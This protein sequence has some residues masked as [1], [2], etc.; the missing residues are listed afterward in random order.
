MAGR[1][2]STIG[3]I[4]AAVVVVRKREREKR[5]MRALSIRFAS[6]LSDTPSLLQA[7]DDRIEQAGEITGACVAGGD[8]FLV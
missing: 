3:A 4:A 5:L 2:H 1:T 7:L 6:C 8:D